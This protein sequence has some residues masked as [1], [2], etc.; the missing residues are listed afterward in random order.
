M[1]KYTKNAHRATGLQAKLAQQKMT[2]KAVI[3]CRE[4]DKDGSKP[5]TGGT[6]EGPEFDDELMDRLNARNVRN[7]GITRLRLQM[8]Q[9]L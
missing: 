5:D 3:D 4:D 8:V 7:D 1:L 2:T 9:T 6:W